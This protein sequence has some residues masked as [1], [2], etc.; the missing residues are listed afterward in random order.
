VEAG[1]VCLLLMVQGD[2]AAIT[3]AHLVVAAKTGLLAV[4]PALGI[5]FTKYARYLLNRWTASAFLG[6]CTFLSD[7]AMHPSHYPGAYTEAALTGIGACAFSLVVSYTPVGRKI[8][9]LAESFLHRT[10]GRA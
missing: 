4:A 3:A 8:D 6:A 10:H 1:A 2:V 9:G 5:T 7:A